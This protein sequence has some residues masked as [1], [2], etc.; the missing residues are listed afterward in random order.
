MFTGGKI[1][2]NI[3]GINNLTAS[4]LQL[5]SQKA[6]NKTCFQHLL[7][8]PPEVIIFRRWLARCPKVGQ[9]VPP[10]GL[11][12]LKSN[13]QL[14]VF[15]GLCLEQVPPHFPFDELRGF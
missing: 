5:G 13:N 11:L 10:Y 14:R 4:Q 1:K 12:V 7:P 8:L 2:L 15:P 9:P 3:P 6:L